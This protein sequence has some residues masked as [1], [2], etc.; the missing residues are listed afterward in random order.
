MK[1]YGSR[2]PM[3]KRTGDIGMAKRDKQ[4]ECTSLGG[5]EMELR[6]GTWIL[7]VLET[8]LCMGLV[9]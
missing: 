4:A 1:V 2:H 7:A 8:R 6:S 5:R 3:S 9:R